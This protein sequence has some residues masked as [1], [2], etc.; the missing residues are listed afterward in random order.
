MRSRLMLAAFCVSLLVNGWMGWELARE[1]IRLSCAY[2]Q[3]E[4]FSQQADL[5]F[6]HQENLEY[7]R[8]YYPSG[9]WQSTGSVLDI[10][11]ERNRKLAEWK[12][13]SLMSGSSSRRHAVQDRA[14]QND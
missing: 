3:T 13:E 11:V 1:S 4:V 7:V 10:I 5:A 2:E 6:P 9:S 12:I 8:G 14:V